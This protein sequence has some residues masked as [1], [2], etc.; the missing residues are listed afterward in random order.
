M[1]MSGGGILNKQI[2]Q[3]QKERLR[4][5]LRLREK[6][7]LALVNRQ[8]QRRRLGFGAGIRAGR[9]CLDGERLQ[10]RPELCRAAVDGGA[11]LGARH[12]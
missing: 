6:Q 9:R 12:R 2:M 8:D 3:Q 7:L 11:K 1:T 10:V 5:L 4:F